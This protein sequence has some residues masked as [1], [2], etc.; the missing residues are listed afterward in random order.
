MHIYIVGAGSIDSWPRS[1]GVPA[2]PVR[3]GLAVLASKI[4][5]VTKVL[6]FSSVSDSQFLCGSGSGT[7]KCSSSFGPWN[8]LPDP[9]SANNSPDPGGISLDPYHCCMISGWT[10]MHHSEL[11]A[12][13]IKTTLNWKNVFFKEWSVFKLNNLHNC[14]V[15]DLWCTASLCAVAGGRGLWRRAVPTAS[16]NPPVLWSSRSQRGISSPL[17]RSGLAGTVFFSVGLIMDFR[18]LKQCCAT[19]IILFRLL[20][21][22]LRP[23]ISH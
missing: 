22:W 18:G 20:F 8:V 21:L 23:S 12:K 9:G 16:L 15:Q 3:T 14:Y 11:C 2:P 6:L 17:R 19:K 13:R 7:P 1:T 4:S 10:I 5:K